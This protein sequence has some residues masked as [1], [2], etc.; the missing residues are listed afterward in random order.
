M[1]PAR[2]DDEPSGRFMSS[3]AEVTGLAALF[4]IAATGASVAFAFRRSSWIALGALTGEHDPTAA[5]SRVDAPLVF[6]AVAIAAAV[7]AWVAHRVTKA[8]GGRL[9]LTALAAAA[10]SGADAPI[11]ATTL[12]R[13][14]GTWIASFA[15]V[16]VGRE[17]AI[18][19]TAGAV[20]ATVDRR[21][22]WSRGAF[23][24][25]GISAAFAAAY[26]APVAAVLYVEEH[27]GIRR[28]PRAVAYTV[29]G[30]ALSR[31]LLAVVFGAHPIFP[32]HQGE[33]LG[34]AVLGAIGLVP[35]ALA[36]RLFLHIRDRT[37]VAAR[38]RLPAPARVTL[39]AA[40][41]GLLV[42][43]APL[44]AGNGME[45]LRFAADH[46]TVTVA[47][48]LG[49]G[50]LLATTAALASGVPGGAFSPT[51][52]LSAGASLGV[53]LAVTGAGVALPSPLWDG[54]LLAMVAGIAVGLQAPLTAAFVVPEMA[55]DVSLL[56]L[57]ILAAAGAT[58][59]D[60]LLDRHLQRW[61]GGRVAPLHD[62]DA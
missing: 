7:A 36:A 57:A 21:T 20:G 28:E 12:T 16:S 40:L 23:T 38:D 22:R 5:A 6:A 52:A 8:S 35:A 42:A 44:T 56:P 25:G 17:S 43:A 24:A 41:V 47:L 55:G 34:V 11:V 31:A 60:R 14:A 50:K 10:R 29:T 1:I 33:L 15:M 51:M 2:T 3:R 49:V 19:E 32:A 26:H 62:E 61:K 59:I 4:A 53:Y 30:A 18:L 9:G 13:A 48:A 58:A 37:A 46:P 27:V 54:M 39:L 45:A